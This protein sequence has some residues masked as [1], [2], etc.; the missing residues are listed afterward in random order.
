MSEDGAEG[1]VERSVRQSA[2]SPASSSSTSESESERPSHKKKRRQ[3]E[4]GDP[5]IDALIAQVGFLS[6][7]CLQNFG[8]SCSHNSLQQ[9]EP[10]AST[11]QS[12]LTN[13][14]EN[15]RAF[16]LGKIETD[17]D[18]NKVIKPAVQERVQIIKEMQQFGQPSWKQVRYSKALQ[19][20]TAAPAF[21]DLKINDE[22]CHFNKDKDYLMGTERV[23]AALSNVALEQ[24][25]LVR[26][27]LQE[28]VDWAFK[29][30]Q[31]LNPTALFDKLTRVFGAGSHYS[32]NVEE[33]LQI[34]CGKRA[35]CI[36]IRRERL[37]QEIT[38]RNIQ[39]AI[40]NV[41]P[42]EEY[43]F[44]KE[45]LLQV[46]HSLG[47]PQTWLTVP[48]CVKDRRPM[49]RKYVEPR[50]AQVDTGGPYNTSNPKRQKLGK[51]FHRSNE[52]PK[53]KKSSFR[54]P[55]SRDAK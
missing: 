18:K 23:M 41:P 50:Q 53:G 26:T 22:L 32:K 38:N 30:P 13:P 27:G 54:P 28:I 44:D 29:A 5:R 48:A 37:L 46:V 47:G 2:S 7:M 1:S 43:L 33:G 20:F 15:A 3:D 52:K 49:K 16:D 19:N 6:N 55:S 12:F 39:T 24:R 14:N 40:R 36:E 9:N 25:E 21:R 17:F 51:R 34:V 35:E 11:S 10:V 42:S 31:E 45:I 4:N 8:G